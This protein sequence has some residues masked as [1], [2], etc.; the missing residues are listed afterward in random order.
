MG[1]VFVGTMCAIGV[2]L[3][4]YRGLE[5]QDDVAGNLACVFAVGLALFP[6][7][8]EGAEGI[9]AFVGK[10]H[11]IFAAAFFLT[12]VY[13]SLR[14]FTK[15]NPDLTPT[16]RKLARNRVYRTCGW[17]MLVCIVLIAALKLAPGTDTWVTRTKA[18]F[19]LESAAVV[20]FGV[21]WLVKGEAILGDKPA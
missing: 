19:W 17:V 9:E 10:L 20:A 1:D 7:A 6:T 4:S 5:N 15:T 8:R 11:F 18:V 12:L 16:P 2:F 21:S 14:L 3:V 13:F